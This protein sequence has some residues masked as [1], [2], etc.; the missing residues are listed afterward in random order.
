VIVVAG[1]LLLTPDALL[2]R[3]IAIDHWNLLVWRGLLQALVLS[4]I[5]VAL[6]GWATPAVFRA[7][8][9]RGLL[10]ALLIAASTFLFIV[11]LSY[12]TVANVL[13]IMA[14][15]P[16]FAAITS[17]I[18]LGEPV[19]AF[20]WTAIAV[21]MAGIAL[22]AYGSVDAK[23]PGSLLGDLLALGGAL[24]L[25]SNFTVLRHGRAVNMI[26]AMVMSGLLVGALAWLLAPALVLEGRQL[27]YLGIMGLV[28]APIPF[29]LITIGLRSLPA[30]EACLLMLL[31]TVLGPLWVWLVIGETP[32]RLALVGGVLVVATLA[33]HS[34]LAQRA[35]AAPAT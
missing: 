4:L 23:T 19:R 12:T 13:I 27:L 34:I 29:A 3:L 18:F 2:I 17:R 24:T 5:L 1:V 35:Q 16:F 21:A 25:G 31:E 9:R 15:A 10:C 6:N 20:T 28:V 32:G 11:A 33:G 7:V 22:L 8:G 26:P 14:A 30:P